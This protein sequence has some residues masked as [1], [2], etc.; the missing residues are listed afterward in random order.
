MLLTKIKIYGQWRGMLI[1]TG[2]VRRQEEVYSMK[3]KSIRAGEGG[4]TT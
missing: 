4:S 2:K 3:A 1:L